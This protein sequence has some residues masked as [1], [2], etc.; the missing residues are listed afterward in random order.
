MKK[1]ITLDPKNAEYYF[2]ASK[3]HWYLD[4]YDEALLALEVAI[5]LDSQIAKYYLLKYDYFL[6]ISAKKEIYNR[7]SLYNNGRGYSYTTIYNQFVLN[8]IQD[9]FWNYSTF[10]QYKT[11]D[12]TSSHFVEKALEAINQ[13]IKLDPENFEYQIKKGETL[14]RLNR[15]NEVIAIYDQLLGLNPSFQQRKQLYQ[16][17]VAVYNTLLEQIRSE[18]KLYRIEL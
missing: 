13:A 3:Y 4:K 1:A 14:L 7:L 10:V 18:A 5:E 6:H 11:I 9:L 17:K 16:L 12:M 15:H 8:P 2:S